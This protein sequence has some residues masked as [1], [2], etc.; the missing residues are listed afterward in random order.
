MYEGTCAIHQWQRREPSRRSA[1]L[2]MRRGESRREQTCYDMAISR[3]A[4]MT[5]RGILIGFVLW[6]LN[7]TAPPYRHPR[8]PTMPLAS[9]P[10]KPRSIVSNLLLRAYGGSAC[11]T[12]RS[13]RAHR[14]PKMRRGG[15]RRISRTRLLQQPQ[16]EIDCSTQAE[17]KQQR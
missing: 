5:R 7:A 9:S 15:S 13:D 1:A 6:V 3:F 4:R 11:P 10:P 12:I 17:A 16:R 2:R 14:Y 8:S